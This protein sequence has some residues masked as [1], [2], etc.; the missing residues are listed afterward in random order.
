[1]ARPSSSLFESIDATERHI[2]EAKRLAS[3]LGVFF[4]ASGAAEPEASLARKSTA[5]LVHVPPTLV[6]DVF[7]GPWTRPALLHRALL[8]ARL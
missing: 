7:H 3:E 4:D 1:M 2:D 8:D 5:A 6:A